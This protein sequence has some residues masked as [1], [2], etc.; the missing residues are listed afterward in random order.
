[1]ELTSTYHPDSRITVCSDDFD[2]TDITCQKVQA[3]L[4]N[5]KF[6]LCPDKGWHWCRQE[7]GTDK[8]ESF[9]FWLNQVTNLCDRFGKNR[10]KPAA[11]PTGL[12]S[13]GNF[14][15]TDILAMQNQIAQLQEEIERLKKFDCAANNSLQRLRETLK[16]HSAP[17]E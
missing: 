9:D 17:Q 6:K 2:P 5:K 4:E 13:H 7:F 12:E 10:P 11:D 1:M 8:P 14:T 3:M 16:E 15:T